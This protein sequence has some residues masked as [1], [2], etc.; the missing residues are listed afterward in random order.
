MKSRGEAQTRVR[1]SRLVFVGAV[2]AVAS[3]SCEDG[4]RFCYPGDYRSCGC[5]DPAITGY[6]QCDA[7]GEAYAACDCSGKVP[8]VAVAAGGS[9]SGGEATG[10]GG[11]SEMLPFMSECDTN[12]QCETGLCFPFNAKGPHCTQS[13]AGPEDCPPPADGCNNMGVCKAP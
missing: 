13:C 1:W 12:E 11:G 10:G 9:G 7:N 3:T 2:A 5:A 8:G 4:D 6:E